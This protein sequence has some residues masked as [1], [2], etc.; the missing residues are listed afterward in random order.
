[1]A[2]VAGD[3]AAAV[4]DGAGEAAVGVDLDVGDAERAAPV[5]GAGRDAAGREDG[6]A[7]GAAVEGIVDGVE[8]EGGAVE[9]EGDDGAAVDQREEVLAR[10]S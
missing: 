5:E 10:R 2:V 3:G 6:E 1:M 7:H 9:A 8:V 4:V